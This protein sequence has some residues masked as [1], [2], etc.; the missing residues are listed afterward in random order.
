MTLYKAKHESVLQRFRTTC[1]T[2]CDMPPEAMV[3]W[4]LAELSN[5]DD[6]REMGSLHPLKV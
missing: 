2:W 5:V 4:L 1:G 3:N 6:V